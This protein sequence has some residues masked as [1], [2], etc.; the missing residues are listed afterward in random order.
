MTERKFEKHYGVLFNRKSGSIVKTLVD[1]HGSAFLK[2]FAMGNVSASRDFVV[3]NAVDGKI[4]G[5]YEGKKNDMPNICKDME[6][7]YISDICEG[8]L[9]ALEADE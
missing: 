7:K 5:Y 6:G 9:E 2:M 4:V 3:F 8:L 1:E